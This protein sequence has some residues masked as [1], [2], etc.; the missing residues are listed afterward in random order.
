MKIKITDIDRITLVVLLGL[1]ITI[2]Y[3][4][5]L[6]W[7][8]SFSNT[9]NFQWSDPSYVSTKTATPIAPINLVIIGLLPIAALLFYNKIQYSWYILVFFICYVS[10][11][12]LF[13]S[14]NAFQEFTFYQNS[15][16][17]E[18]APKAFNIDSLALFH[19]LLYGVVGLI[20]LTTLYF[21][22][23]RTI[24]DTFTVNQKAQYYPVFAAIIATM[25]HIYMAYFY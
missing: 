7:L 8:S 13:A 11:T 3:P 2:L 23:K 17:S 24:R 10:T 21:C 14:I 12:L 5:C 20:L 15:F 9:G 16:Y 6:T 19:H 22:Y 4:T 18:Y 1:L 25:L